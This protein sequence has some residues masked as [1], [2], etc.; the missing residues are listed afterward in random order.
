MAN[1]PQ[2][3]AKRTPLSALDELY[4]KTREERRAWVSIADAAEFLG[5]SRWTVRRMIADGALDAQRIGSQLKVH[6]ARLITTPKQVRPEDVMP[7]AERQK[8]KFLRGWDEH[9]ADAAAK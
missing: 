3:P 7:P 1:T 5:V 2:T 6:K 8:A 9:A 4:E